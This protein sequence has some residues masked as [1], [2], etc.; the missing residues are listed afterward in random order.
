MVRRWAQRQESHT[1]TWSARTSLPSRPGSSRLLCI[2]RP[3]TH[4]AVAQMNTSRARCYQWVRRFTAQGDAGLPDRS[5]GPR[6]PPLRA[7]AT[8]EAG[9][10]VSC[11]SAR[12][13]PVRTGRT[14][15]CPNRRSPASSPVTAYPGWPAAGPQLRADEA[16]RLV[17][18]TLL[19]LQ[20]SAADGTRPDLLLADRCAGRQAS[21]RPQVSPGA[22]GSL[23]ANRHPGCLTD[24][25]RRLRWVWSSR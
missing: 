24:P 8:I 12:I 21:S 9:V 3:R 16:G 4:V 1:L 5:G 10:C 11:V 25:K 23:A 2:V 7:P 19:P 20:S 14:W 15:G 18:V 6:A 13:G 22:P 17:H